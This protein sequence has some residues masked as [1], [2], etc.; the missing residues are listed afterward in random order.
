MDKIT[1][2]KTLFRQVCQTIDIVLDFTNGLGYINRG[3]IVDGHEDQNRTLNGS[4]FTSENDDESE[5]I[6]SY[7]YITIGLMW[8]PALAYSLVFLVR[9]MNKNKKQGKSFFNLEM[10]FLI[11][12]GPTIGHFLKFFFHGISCKSF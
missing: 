1:Y 12:Y 8:A 3:N 9:I 4:V 5:R 2:V 7:G 10:V 11:L 6:V